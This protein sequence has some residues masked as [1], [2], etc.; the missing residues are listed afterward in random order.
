MFRVEDVRQ[1][2]LDVSFC[3][4]VLTVGFEYWAS[5]EPYSQN[6]TVRHDIRALLMV[7]PSKHLIL[8]SQENLKKS[9]TLVTLVLHCQ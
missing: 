5:L 9:V 8:D 2:R 1:L 6:S 3:V 7:C 4:G